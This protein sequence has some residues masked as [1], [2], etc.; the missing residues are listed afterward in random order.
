MG[1]I[2]RH[3]SV[4]NN[5]F[6]LSPCPLSLSSVLVLCPCPLSLSSVLVPCPC[7]CPCPLPP[8][9][10]SPRLLRSTAA[11]TRLTV[12]P[13]RLTAALFRLTAA[14]FR[15]T[16]APFR[17]TTAPSR[18]TATR[19]YLEPCP[20]PP[21]TV[22]LMPPLHLCPTQSIKCVL[23]LL[24]LLMM[25]RN[26]A[27]TLPTLKALQSIDGFVSQTASPIR[28]CYLRATKDSLGL[29]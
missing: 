2:A 1:A 18:S 7:P 25:G 15:L 23:Q 19:R 14:P 27:I 16:T 28:Y 24:N 5:L 22:I 3:R 29:S 21:V 12:A 9:V 13:F 8:P 11:P 17:L 20:D 26:E 4:R 10:S 6:T